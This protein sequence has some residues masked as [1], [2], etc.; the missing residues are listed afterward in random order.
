MKEIYLN[1]DSPCFSCPIYDRMIK[2]ANFNQRK[3]E[4]S[5]YC[6]TCDIYYLCKMGLAFKRYRDNSVKPI[7]SRCGKFIEKIELSYQDG[8]DVKP[9]NGS[10]ILVIRK[11]NG[12]KYH[13]LQTIKGSYF[14]DLAE[15][16]LYVLYTF[17]FVTY[18]IVNYNALTKQYNRIYFDRILEEKVAIKN[19]KPT[20]V[21]ERIIFTGID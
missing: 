3:L 17:G 7:C 8:Q 4:G 13:I 16:L 20:Y 5:Y 21:N 1:C 9:F 10:S 2:I 19:D 15:V 18:D 11:P 14:T 12:D 6:E